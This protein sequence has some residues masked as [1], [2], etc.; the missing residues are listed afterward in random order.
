MHNSN[1]LFLARILLYSFLP[2]FKLNLNQAS[3]CPHSFFFNIFQSIS[4]SFVKLCK[5]VCFFSTFC[6]ANLHPEQSKGCP[7]TMPSR[8]AT[9]MKGQCAVRPQ[10][11]FGQCYNTE[12]TADYLPHFKGFLFLQAQLVFLFLSRASPTL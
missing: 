3:I 11:I 5:L 4:C 7:T 2:Q 8:T 1:P 12:S 6:E 9:R 10:S